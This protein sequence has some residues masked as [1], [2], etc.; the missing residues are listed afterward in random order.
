VTPAQL[1]ASLDALTEDALRPVSATL[2]GLYAFYSLVYA[3]QLDQPGARVGLVMSAATFAAFLVAFLVVRQHEVPRRWVGAVGAA[4]GLVVGANCLL[5]EAATHNPQLSPNLMLCIVSVPL[6]LLDLRWLSLVVVSLA[7]G[8]FVV[9]AE[10]LPGTDWQVQTY[11]LLSSVVVAGLVYGVRRRSHRR[12]EEARL[13]LRQAAVVDELTGVYNRRGFLEAGQE[14]VDTD[15]ELALLFLDVDGLKAVNDS[16]GH[17]AGDALLRGA[18]RTLQRTFRADDVIGRL[19]GDEFAV[20]LG[21]PSDLGAGLSPVERLQ[22]ALASRT[23]GLSLSVGLAVAAP[24][25]SLEQL[26]SRGDKDMYAGRTR[27]PTAGRRTG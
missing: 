5:S 24:G 11:P 7:A 13:A 16:L 4:Y 3:A 14:L 12:L 25:E 15:V 27:R 18:A 9:Q 17:D 22:D 23:D 2:I 19:G 20:L 10:A 1:R 6:F 21:N 8:W 26:L